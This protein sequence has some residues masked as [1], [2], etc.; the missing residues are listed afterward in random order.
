MI[1]VCNIT[2]IFLSFEKCLFS[3]F[4]LRLLPDVEK[5]YIILFILCHWQIQTLK[6][7]D[8]RLHRSFKLSDFGLGFTLRELNTGL[9]R[10]FLS[11]NK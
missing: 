10:L 11:Q 5:Y 8:E 9:A 6:K 3:H 2:Y 1:P 7:D 4:Q